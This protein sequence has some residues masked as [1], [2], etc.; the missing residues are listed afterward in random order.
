[1]RPPGVDYFD[2]YAAVS[3][4]VEVNSSS[5]DYPAIFQL[6]I[7]ENRASFSRE[8]IPFRPVVE[9]YKHLDY[10]PICHLKN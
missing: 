10:V 2:R 8:A 5:Q 6:Y 4:R 7:Y 9:G 3:N 1:V